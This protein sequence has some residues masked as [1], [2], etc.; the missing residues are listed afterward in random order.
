MGSDGLMMVSGM[1]VPLKEDFSS[2][3]AV[4]DVDRNGR[5]L[6]VLEMAVR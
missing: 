4:T 3:S 2:G 6:M 1:A 5:R